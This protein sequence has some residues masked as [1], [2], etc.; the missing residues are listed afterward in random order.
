M[1][2]PYMP[3]L[4]AC[5]SLKEKNRGLATDFDEFKDCDYLCG[6]NSIS[7]S[8]SRT[9]QLLDGISRIERERKAV[10]ILRSN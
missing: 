9:E 7:L 10:A 5:Q 8:P 1:L 2:W 6:Q 3:K 4:Q